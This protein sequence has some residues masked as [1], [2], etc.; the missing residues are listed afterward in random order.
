MTCCCTQLLRRYLGVGLDLDRHDDD[1]ITVVEKCVE[2]RCG[3]QRAGSS[4]TRIRARS[5]TGSVDSSY[6]DASGSRRLGRS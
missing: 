5:G 2:R 6:P 3:D 1:V 4:E